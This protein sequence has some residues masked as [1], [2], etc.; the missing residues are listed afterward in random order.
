MTRCIGSL[1]AVQLLMP[2]SADAGQ[3][4]VFSLNQRAV[5]TPVVSLSNH[6]KPSL[7]VILTVDKAQ[8][9]FE[10]TRNN[11]NQKVIVQINGETVSEAIVRAEISGGQIV[12]PQDDED[13]AIR[14]AKSLMKK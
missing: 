3:Y 11:L 10:F 6:A 14:L 8:E 13:T 9:L 12:F 7:E 4:T 2:I 1:I 5:T